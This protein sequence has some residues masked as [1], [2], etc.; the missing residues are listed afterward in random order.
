MPSS[1]RKAASDP[2][3]A[4]GVTGVPFENAGEP[5][6]PGMSTAITSRSAASRSSTGSQTTSSPPSGWIRSSGSP[7]PR[8]TW[9]RAIDGQYVRA[10]SSDH[11]RR[12]YV[13][14]MDLSGNVALVT[15]ANRGIGRAIAEE[16]AKRP[17][18]LL[19]VRHALARQP[20]A[21]GAAAGGAREVRPVVV[22]LSSR[23]AV[24]RSWAG[25]AASRRSTCS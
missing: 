6:K 25:L 17:L 13:Q 23:E 8:R 2:A 19:L 9:F 11:A 21:A 20:R 22:D 14:A 1:S 12:P 7:E 15:G 24:E 4:C 16:L 5:P 10:R 18:D 3:S